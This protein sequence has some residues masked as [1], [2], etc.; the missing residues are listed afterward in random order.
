[1]EEQLKKS[2]NTTKEY[3]TNMSKQKRGVFIFSGVGILLFSILVVVWLNLSGNKL[4]NLYTGLDPKEASDVYTVL[5]DLGVTAQLDNT[6]AI[7]VPKGE[8]ETLRIQL[9]AK[10]YPKTALNYDIFSSVNGLTSTEFEKRVGLVHQAQNRLQDTLMRMHGISKAV[11]NINLAQ[12]GNYIWEQDTSKSTAS[13]LLT[14][15]PGVEFSKK[16]VSAIKSLVATSLPKLDPKDVTV[17]NSETHNE[18]FGLD[19]ISDASSDLEEAILRL[20]LERQMEQALEDKV[21]KQLSLKYGP[22]EMR[23]SATVELNYDKM[24]SESTQY[25]PEGD[26]QAGVITKV[27][28]SYKMDSSKTT[29]GIVGEEQNTDIPIVVDK[30]GDGVPEAVDHQKNVDYVVSYIKQQVERGSAE[31]VNKTVAI[32]VKDK[33]ELTQQRK[34]ELI[35]QVSMATNIPLS[36]ISIENALSTTLADPTIQ[37]NWLQTVK[38]ILEDPTMMA[39]ILLLIVALIVTIMLIAAKVKRDKQKYM[40]VEEYVAPDGTT[41]MVGEDT[42]LEEETKKMQKAMEEKKRQLILAAEKR[43]TEESGITNEIKQFTKVHPEIT[44]SL[45]RTWLREEE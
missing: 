19:E 25:K 12:T 35:E 17:V 24:I 13:V 22:D 36:N 20:G 11:V 26:S 40:Y 3:F 32:M 18:M 9:A 8:V 21:S 44:A 14:L 2:F 38:N 23:V 39:T 43:K 30:N 33:Y 16:Q 41:T 31:V 4:V 15:Y 5:Q 7:K 27:E 42:T 1:M 6:G 10:G 45:I 37:D 34:D 28:E 29:S